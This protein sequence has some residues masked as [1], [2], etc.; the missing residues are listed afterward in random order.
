[1]IERGETADDSAAKPEATWDGTR[2]LVLGETA[3][4]GCPVSL[5]GVIWEEHPLGRA[6]VLLPLQ[7]T[8]L[9]WRVAAGDG[10]TSR[11]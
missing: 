4:L 9:T 8:P 6:W 7:L 5:R 2:F 1:M 10:D 11:R 3:L